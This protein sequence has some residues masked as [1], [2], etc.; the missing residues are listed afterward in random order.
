MDWYV[1]SQSF[2]SIGWIRSDMGSWSTPQQEELDRAC[3]YKARQIISC[4]ELVTERKYMSLPYG[5]YLKIFPS[6]RRWVPTLL[7]ETKFLVGGKVHGMMQ[8]ALKVLTIYTLTF[9]LKIHAVPLGWF[10]N[11]SRY[12]PSQRS[13]STK[14]EM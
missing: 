5:C 10:V 8:E 4:R 9:M 3:G 6:L 13:Q 7:E 1:F 2:H 14:I 12:R 11:N